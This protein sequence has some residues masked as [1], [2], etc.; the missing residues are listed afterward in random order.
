[1]IDWIQGDRMDGLRLIGWRL[2]DWL[3]EGDRLVGGCQI[4]WRVPEWLE[5]ARLGGD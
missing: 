1:M 3:L 4:G 2:P 5:G